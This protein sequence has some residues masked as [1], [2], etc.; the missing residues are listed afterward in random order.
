MYHNKDINIVFE[1]LETSID[2]LT[3]VEANKRLK[4]YGL[5]SLPVRR[6]KSIFKILFEELC[7][8]IEVILL[9][10]LL[11]SFVVQEYIDCIAL[12]VIILVDVIM[13]VYQEWKDWFLV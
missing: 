1:E 5:N 4:K 11:L 9:I 8:P 13:G 3:I 12:L 2:G 6:R 7:N 10:T